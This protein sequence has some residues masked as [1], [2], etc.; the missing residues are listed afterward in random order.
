[1]REL[2]DAL[3]L[4]GGRTYADFPSVYDAASPLKQITAFFPP[5]MIMHGTK[6]ETVPYSQSVNL[7][8]RMS[9]LQIPHELVT[10]DGG[11][12]LANLSALEQERLDL[13]GLRWFT[14]HLGSGWSLF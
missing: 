13:I 4:F 11:H 10:F 9:E 6:D 7:D 14:S 2:I 3:P 8:R 12:S 1:M 5:T